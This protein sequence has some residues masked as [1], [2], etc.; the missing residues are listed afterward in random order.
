MPP[1]TMDSTLL[2]DIAGSYE[3]AHSSSQEVIDKLAAALDSNWGCAGSDSAGAAW[4]AS[5]DPA[6]YDALAA[7]TTV[8]NAFGKM[9][10]LLAFTAVNHANTENA[11]KNP[12]EPPDGPPAQLPTSNSPTFNGAYGGDTDEP[13][14]WGLVSNWLQ[15]HT[16]PNGDP[17]K[18][19]ALGSAWREAAKGLREAADDT[20]SGFA[21]LDDIDSGEVPQILAQMDLVFTDTE[22]VATQF[23]NLASSCNDW[24]DKIEDAH[25][26]VLA[27]LAG[28]LGV[29]LIVGGIAGFFTVGTG[30]VA[31]AGAAAVWQAHPSLPSSSPSMPQPRLR[32]EPQLPPVSQSVAWSPTCNRYSK[33]TPPCST[34]AR[35]AG[36]G[37]GT[38]TSR[39]RRT[40][41]DS[42]THVP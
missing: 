30:A 39:H 18:L 23:E 37:A 21:Q 25:R 28:A 26:K 2:A 36:A 7:G 22:H 35:A 33:R 10:D 19:R 34:R 3:T 38:T 29:G 15:G 14:G 40:C 11:N 12:P 20:G 8:A 13:F 41:L 1:I 6:A 16:W 9:H 32:S 24:A 31:A 4:A 5:Y 42:R 27:I 17:E